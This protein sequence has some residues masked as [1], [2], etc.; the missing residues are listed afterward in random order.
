MK[1]IIVMGIPHHGNIGD[2]A[3]ALAEETLLKKYFSD[4]KIFYM[5]E[6]YLDK[7]AKRVKNI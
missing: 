4:Y 7:C 1:K 2:N 5:Q 3:I 6:K